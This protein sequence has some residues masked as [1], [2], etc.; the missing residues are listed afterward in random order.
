M[1]DVS[2]GFFRQPAVRLAAGDGRH[3]V[4]TTD[5]R[6]DLVQITAVDTL[7]AEFSG[8][9]VLAENYLYTAEAFEEYLS[10]LAPGGILSIALGDL[11]PDAP[12]AAG[13]MV[14][15]AWEALRARG[16]ADP[17]RHIAVIDSRMLYVEILVR[18]EPFDAAQ[19][20][21]LAAHAARMQFAPLW[22]PGGTG[23][24]VY[25]RLVEATGAERERLLAELPFLV[26]PTTD[27]D[28]FFFS[29]F[30]WRDLFD[31]GTL[32][33]AHTTALGQIVLG[34]L[35]VTLSALGAVFVLA[36]LLVRRRQ[37]RGAGRAAVGIL[38]YFL[39]VGIGF[40]LFEISFIQRF[41]LFLG[42]PTYSL[43]VTL[44]ALLVFLGCGSFLSRRWVGRERVA[45][46]VAVCL[47]A[48]LA[49]FYIEG[50]A[51]L[52]ARFLG[53]S[54][55]VRAAVTTAVIA[56]LG[57]VLGLFLPLGI[58]QAA[59]VHAD[60]IPWAWGV[61]GCASVTGG[62]LAVVLATSFGFRTVW[63]LSIVVYA[64][65]VAALLLA[66]RSAPGLHGARRAP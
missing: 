59:A 49:L 14:S 29:F 37:V 2:D 44:F 42:Y 21:R 64:L 8:A 12:R 34:A 30:R 61:N 41:V 28:P 63:I 40:M 48:A 5:D 16:I 18:A 13:R 1:N 26:G 20:A 31:P 38:V 11:N 10:H 54:L 62:V 9:Y 65:G 23:H 4:R 19:V 6:F 7:A 22:L 43:T 3:F 53:S 45:L 47:I 15:V 50:L 60:L 57:L 52:Q 39:A 25:R 27:D 36:P 35:L 55:M 56:P 66:K 24:P 58:R 51:G 17:G 46:P 32:T 33:P